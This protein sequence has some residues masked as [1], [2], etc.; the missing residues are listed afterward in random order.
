MRQL[1]RPQQLC[2]LVSQPLA[3]VDHALPALL[4]RRRIHA[5]E[6]LPIGDL[7]TGKGAHELV[8]RGN[9]QRPAKVVGAG[10]TPAQRLVEPPRDDVTIEVRVQYETVPGTEIEVEVIVEYP[11][12]PMHPR[13]RSR[14]LHP[15][16]QQRDRPRGQKYVS[17]VLARERHVRGRQ[18][19]E[20][21]EWSRVVSAMEDVPPHLQRE[22]LAADEVACRRQRDPAHQQQP[23]IARRQ[24]AP[25]GGDDVEA[26]PGMAEDLPHTVGAQD[27][28]QRPR[29]HL[30]DFSRRGVLAVALLV[31]VG[32]MPARER[33]HRVALRQAGHPPAPDGRADQVKRPGAGRRQ[34]CPEE[35]PV[36]PRQRQ[37]LGPPGGAR[38]DVHIFRAQP[39][40]ADEAEGV[41]SGA[42]GERVHASGS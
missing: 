31:D 27:Q 28:V 29:Q 40:L 17:Q 22:R 6:V 24:A 4:P 42:E 33:R 12:V 7:P 14:D 19:G 41:R 23:P 39:T 9:E 34:E 25:L 10:T 26:R 2:H 38:H 21:A 11:A 37:P 1:S 32:V 20:R 15:F 36:E 30:R 5:V 8:A 3:L 16:H 18:V 35:E 13:S